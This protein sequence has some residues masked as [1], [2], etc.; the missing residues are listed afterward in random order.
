MLTPTRRNRYAE[1]AK[2][3]T[4]ENVIIQYQPTKFQNTTL[5]LRKDI[6]HQNTTNPPFT[7]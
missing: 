3:A 2:R 4:K 6:S 1:I 7:K 5:L